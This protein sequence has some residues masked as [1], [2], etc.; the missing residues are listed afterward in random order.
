MK[1]LVLALGFRCKRGLGGQLRGLAKNRKV[2]ID[3]T[4][5]GIVLL[6]LRD[7]SGSRRTR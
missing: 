5:T 4:D 6:K 1:G 2:L 3:D 7:R